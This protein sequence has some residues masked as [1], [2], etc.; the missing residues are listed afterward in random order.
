MH[1]WILQHQADFELENALE[2]AASLGL[3][4]EQVRE[5]MQSE[6]VTSSLVRY[7]QA[8]EAIDI[9]WAG[10]LYVNGRRVTALTPTRELLERIIAAAGESSAR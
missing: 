5:R 3:D 1:A 7:I 6:A 9:K 2:F 4:A 8:V 10:K